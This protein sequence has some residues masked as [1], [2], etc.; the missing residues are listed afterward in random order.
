MSPETETRPREPHA[1]R[2][3]RL[4]VAYVYRTFSEVGSIPSL[5]RRLAERLSADVDLT[6]FCSVRGRERSDAPLT[7]HDVDA[8]VEGSGRLRYAVECASFAARASRA[9]SRERARFDVV[10]TV[11]LA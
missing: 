7:F 9:V 6:L 2:Q 1:L 4:R 10:T 3:T 5:Y 11:G 8:L